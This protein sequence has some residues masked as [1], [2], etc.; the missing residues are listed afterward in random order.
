MGLRWKVTTPGDC[1]NV[2]DKKPRRGSGKPMD[3]CTRQ[4]AALQRPTGQVYSGRAEFSITL[5]FMEAVGTKRGEEEMEFMNQR[6]SRALHLTI[7]TQSGTS[8]VFRN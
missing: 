2:E 8:W 4:K 3:R 1:G 7:W 6:V 5:G